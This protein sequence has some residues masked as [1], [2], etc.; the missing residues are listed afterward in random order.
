[1][2]REEGE[3]VELYLDTMTVADYR[4]CLLQE[5]HL[6]HSGRQSG[7]CPLLKDFGESIVISLML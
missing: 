3:T 7:V 6:Y 4:A 1:M 5:G 2:S